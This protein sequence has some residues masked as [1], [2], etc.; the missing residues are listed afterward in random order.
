MHIF[1]SQSRNRD[2]LRLCRK[3]LAEMRAD[4][5]NPTVSELIDIVLAKPAPAYYVDYIKACHILVQALKSGEIDK[6]TY[7]NSECWEDMFRDLLQLLKRYPSIPLRRLIL[8]LCA[9]E[10][11]SPRF[12]I[13]RRRALAILKP[14]LRN[15]YTL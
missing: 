5:K 1:Y 6:G 8:S 13:T 4:G 7:K 14:H 10:A 2:F 11:G 3:I 15:T 12:Y 9:G